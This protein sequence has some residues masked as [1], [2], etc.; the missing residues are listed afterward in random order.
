MTGKFSPHKQEKSV[1]FLKSSYLVPFQKY[2]PF[3]QVTFVPL[4]VSRG[5][6][7][8][9]LLF[10][11]LFWVRQRIGW[12]IFPNSFCRTDRFERFPSVP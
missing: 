2:L 4:A 1:D 5:R 7:K 8:Q 9:P 11:P 10:P 3:K 6:K 12:L